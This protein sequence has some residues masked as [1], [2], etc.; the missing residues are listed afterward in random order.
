MEKKE[1]YEIRRKLGQGGVGAVYEGYDHHLRR[2]VAVKR[3]LDSDDLD[4]DSEQAVES[5][6]KECHSLSALNS[7]NIVRLFD[8]GQDADGPFVVMELLEGETLEALI[9]KAPLTPAD[10]I[11]VAEQS[12]EGL[13]AAHDA[14]LLHR[15]LKPC[16]FMITWLPSGRMQ[17]KIL[18]FGLAK[19]SVEPSKQTIAHG[20][21]LFGSI[22]FMAPEQFEQFPLD[23][24]TDLYALGTVFYYALAG[25]YPF[26]GESVAQVMASHLSGH[27]T[28]LREYRQDLDPELCKWIMGLI[29]RNPD[30]RPDSCATALAQFMGIQNG[31]FVPQE[32]SLVQAGTVPPTPMMELPP[33][34]AFT[35]TGTIPIDTSSHVMT[36]QSALIPLSQRPAEQTGAVHVHQKVAAHLNTALVPL[37]LPLEVPEEEIGPPRVATTLIN[38]PRV[39]EALKKPQS[40]P[41][42]ILGLIAIVAVFFGAILF[43]NRNSSNDEESSEETFPSATLPPGKELVR[44]LSLPETPADLIEARDLDLDDQLS[45]GE[46]AVA[47]TEEHRQQLELYFP[48][49]DLNGDGFLSTTELSLAYQLA[50]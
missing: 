29:S 8:F 3:L 32:P 24:R 7:P 14:H 16:N 33:I 13:L 5:L 49:I 4:S 10:F 48:L 50:E 21:S 31:T 20:N 40:E 12:L 30:H 25:T 15:D 27:Y 26:N 44:K 37:G 22:F 34:S 35:T 43:F 9:E 39:A 18:D 45:M 19:F 17:L 11:S 1:R 42:L 41:Y 28:D 6:L 38:L 23:A 47:S 36:G 46:F 2:R